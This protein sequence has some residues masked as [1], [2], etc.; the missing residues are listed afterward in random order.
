METSN[1]PLTPVENLLEELC[2][3]AMTACVGGTGFIDKHGDPVDLADVT[4]KDIAKGKVTWDP[5]GS[6]R[7]TSDVNV[8]DEFTA[9]DVQQVLENVA[10]MPISTWNYKTEANV[11]H[12]GPMAQ[13]FAA[14][15]AVG[16][17]DKHIHA[18]D[19][20][21]VALAAIQGLY[22]RLQEKDAQLN[23]LHADVA[24]LKQQLA[25][26]QPKTLAIA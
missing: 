4:V 23:Q 3:E 14:A 20:N 15:F 17:S 11:C 1:T 21:G 10:A 5:N 19:A 25:Q 26:S 22:Q 16:D 6:V 9:V 12:M 7:F 2:D 13:D 18:V 8:K 24:S